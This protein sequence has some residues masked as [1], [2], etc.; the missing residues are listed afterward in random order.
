MKMNKSPEGGGV[1]IISIAITIAIVLWGLVSPQSFG[2]FAGMLNG[3]LTKYYGWGYMLTMNIFVVFCIGIAFSR[4]GSARLGPEDSPAPPSGRRPLPWGLSFTA[5]LSL[6]FISARCPSA[7]RPV[8][9]RRRATRYAYLSSIGGF[10]RGPA[11]R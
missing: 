4:F 1:Y 11:M 10:I 9:P 2:V 8:L 7:P 5:R 6:S 3:G